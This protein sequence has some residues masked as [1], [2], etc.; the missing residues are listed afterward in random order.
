M[1]KILKKLG[2]VLFITVIV[3]LALMVI[4]PFLF[5]DKLLNYGTQLAKDYINAEVSID[6]LNLNLFKSFPDASISLSNVSVKGVDEFKNDT[7]AQ[8]KQLDASVN[9]MSLFGGTI[10]VKSVL[11]DDPKFNIIVLKSGKPNYDIVKSDSTEV[12]EED[13][14]TTSSSFALAL[15]KFEINNMKVTYT[16]SITDVHAVID[17]LNFKLHG[18]LSD[19]ET[20]LAMLMNIAHLDVAM[21]PIIYIND[22]IVDVKSNLDA[23]MENMKFSFKDNLFKINQLGLKLDGWLAVPDTNI[24]MD[25]KF[26]ADNTDFKSVMSMIPAE[27]AKELDGVKTAGTF[28][29]EGGAKGNFNAISFPEFWVNLLIDNARFQYPDLPKSVENINVDVNVSCPGNLDSLFVDAKKVHLNIAENPIDAQLK[30][31]TSAKDIELAGNVNAAL[32][33][34]SLADVVPLEDMT[35]KGFVKAILSF[36]GFL[37]DIDSEQYDKFNAKGDINVT[38]FQTVMTDLPPIDIQKAHLTIS[39]KNGDLEYLNMKMGKSDFNLNGKLYNIFQYVFADSTLKANFNFKSSL[40]DV[41]DIYSYDHSVPETV[42][43]EDTSA[44]EAPEIPKNIDFVLNSNIGQI[45]YDSL[46]INNLTGVIGL[47]NGAAFLNDLKLQMLGGKVFASGVYDAGDIMRP[48]VDLQLDLSQVDVQQTVKSFN[49]VQSLAPIAENCYGDITVKLNFKSFMDHYL[50]P[51]LP[52]VNG[53]GRLVTNS[54]SIKDSKLFN[55]IGTATKNSKLSNPSLKNIDIDFKIVDGNV[56]IDTTDFKLNDQAANFG[57]KLGLDQKL[58]FNFGMTLDN[59]IANELLGKVAGSE[60]SGSIKVIAKI[61]G[62]V[63][64]PKL[65]GFSTSATDVLKEVV[66]EKIQEAKEQLSE[67][68]KQYIQ[69]VKKKADAVIATAKTTRDSLI[70]IAETQ[71]EKLKKEAKEISDKAIADASAQADKLIEKAGSNPLAQAAAKKSAEELKKKAQKE[72]DKALAEAGSK[73]DNLVSAAK[74]QGNKI[75]SQA[76][77]K[78]N[79]MNN[80]AM[81]KA[82]SIKD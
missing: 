36:N 52:T 7:L 51:E 57:G 68:A 20:I 10:K 27:Y 59:S 22:A 3:I 76:E 44:I 2:K 71:C 62:T 64:D 29:F 24:K 31:Q 11:L 60:R 32:E 40:I 48:L 35:L 23:D 41:N 37:S 33:L 65:T 58:D 47:K 25:L 30:V 12:V 66:T 72:A 45:N 18:D 21:G 56:I 74:T 61:G 80:E 39:P 73:A 28:K 77:E 15:K 49:T 50:N 14:D 53:D 75:V 17:T 81:K 82:E 54:I 43:V 8:F 79:Q 46:V 1:K 34:A 38:N 63:T 70:N 42:E 4:I 9:L 26:G 13:I 16:D 67:K 19:K 6:D 55:M 78:A 5:K 69:D